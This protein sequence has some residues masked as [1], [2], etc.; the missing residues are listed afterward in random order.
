MCKINGTKDEAK[1]LKRTVNIEQF[2]G[3]KGVAEIQEEI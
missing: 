3:S 2:A 1:L